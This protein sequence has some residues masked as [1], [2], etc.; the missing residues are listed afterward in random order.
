[1]TGRDHRGRSKEEGTTLAGRC[2]LI[3]I[4]LAFVLSDRAVSDGIRHRPVEGPARGSCLL[5]VVEV[6]DRRASAHGFEATADEEIL[7][8]PSHPRVPE[9]GQTMRAD[10]LEHLGIAGS[11]DM[12]AVIG[13]GDH[14][15]PAST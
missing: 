10:A 1:M 3:E 14:D 6:E 11:D 5:E 15:P 2:Q 8:R 12:G 7:E 4:A 13:F 9:P